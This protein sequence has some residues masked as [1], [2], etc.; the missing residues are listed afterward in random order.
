MKDLQNMKNWQKLG[1]ICYQ[2]SLVGILLFA[3]ICISGFKG[4][5]DTL[6]E[7]MVVV[8]V[9]LVLSILVGLYLWPIYQKEIKR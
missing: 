4:S 3:L 9:C 8:G 5:V 1:F 7:K 2:S 6:I